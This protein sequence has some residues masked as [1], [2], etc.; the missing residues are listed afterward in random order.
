MIDERYS[1]LFATLFR[2]RRLSAA[3]PSSAGGVATLTSGE[4]V[5]GFFILTLTAFLISA[6]FI[7]S[8]LKIGERTLFGCFA[9]DTMYYLT[10]A[11]NTVL[12][13]FITFNQETVTNG[14][15]PLW[16]YILVLFQ[17]ILSPSLENQLLLAF[18]VN[19]LLVTLGFGAALWGVIS[20]LGLRVA[21]I[22]PFLMLPGAFTLFFEP[23]IGHSAGDSA[24]LYSFSSWGFVNGM[25]SGVSIAAFGLFLMTTFLRLARADKHARGP[26]IFSFWPSIWLA[27]IVLARLDNILLVL[28]IALTI[29]LFDNGD[30]SRRVRQNA[31]IFVPVAVFVL[32]YMAYNLVT[33]G[34]VL[35]LSGLQKT[36]FAL[37]GNFKDTLSLLANYR[38]GIARRIL[39]MLMF[40]L[41][42]V[43][44]FIYA[45][46]EFNEDPSK[47]DWRERI[48]KKYVVMLLSGYLFL[49]ATFHFSIVDWPNQGWWYY[50]EDRKSVV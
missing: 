16:Q 39:P 14:F 29:L 24:L 33:V 20:Y 1:K 38:V 37:V 47:E 26:E 7:L 15:Q 22:M 4:R 50:S 6:P 17:W 10:I 32:L 2:A 25:E 44:M 18:L 23:S 46:F 41:S 8:F 31:Q 30:V 42:G 28:S 43:V 34:V 21:G 12:Y 49:K 45:L 40:I 27:A 19:L 35:P 9:A 5:L 13:G 48:F 3:A 36:E 11:K